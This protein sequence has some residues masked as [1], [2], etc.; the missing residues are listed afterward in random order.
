M[1]ENITGGFEL[2]ITDEEADV[3]LAALY[4]ARSCLASLPPDETV[5]Q[6]Y[7]HSPAWYQ[8]KIDPIEQVLSRL[9][10]TK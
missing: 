5:G 1:T 4:F 10:L 8:A 3:L 9:V 7:P 2:E 6:D